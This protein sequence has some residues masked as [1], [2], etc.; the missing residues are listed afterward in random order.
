[1]QCEEENIKS[2]RESSNNTNVK[3]RRAQRKS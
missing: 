2:Y 3:E 1:L